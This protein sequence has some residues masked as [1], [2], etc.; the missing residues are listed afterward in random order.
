MD[1]TKAQSALKRFFGYDS[2]RPMQ[3]EII[4]TVLSGQDTLV[5][6]P[7]GGGK[8][9]C[10]Q[11]P[12]VLLPGI[13]VVVSPLIALMHDQ[14]EG[15]RANGIPAAYMNSTQ[16]FSEVQQLEIALQQGHIKLLYV[17]P[18]KLLSGHFLGFLRALG[19]SL[20]AIDE[21]HCI[22]AWG[23]DFRPEY[24]QLALLKEQ[25]PEVG[26]VALTAT[27]DR[28]TRQDIATQ[29]HMRDPRVFISSFDRPNLSLTVLPGQKKY[30]QIKTFLEQHPRQ[31]GIVYCLSRKATEQVAAKLL[32][33]GY[34][35]AYYH[36]GMSAQER[37]KV[38]NDFL[39]DRTPIICATIA[40]GMGIDKSNVRWVIHYNMPK[41]MEGYY[42]EIGRAGRDG[43]ASDTLLFY[44][45]S[46]VIALRG[47]V[48]DS[49]QK[50]LQM[51]KLDRMQ[52][53]AEAT[54]C[55][56]KILLS[57]FGEV[58]EQERC[59]N[60]DVCE[61]PPETFDGTIIAQKALSAIARL[62]QRQQAVSSTMLVD[63]LRGSSRIDLVQKGY[64]QI[65]TYGAGK[66]LTQAEW[67]S[68][69]L[70]LL[71]QGLLEIAYD[72]GHTLRLTEASRKVLF[73]KQPVRLTHHKTDYT[74]KALKAEQPVPGGH[75]QLENELF[76]TLREVRRKIADEQGVPPYI[77][78]SDKTLRQMAEAMPHSVDSMQKVSGVGEEKLRKYGSAFI[79]A[80]VRFAV[81]KAHQGKEL[82][83]VSPFLTYERYQQGR[84][85][86]DIGKQRGVHINAI[87]DHLGQLY[88]MGYQI[89]L[90]RFIEID[91][92]QAVKQA[93][94]R[95]GS[96]PTLSELQAQLPDMPLPNLRLAMA[97]VRREHF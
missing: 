88:E 1:L 56:R 34:K 41:N 71:H 5:L 7:T 15:L 38:Q 51:A 28:I 50:E 90:F 63:I 80:I 81:L 35:A 52:Q 75:V 66:D 53:Y 11:I 67:N 21:A 25:F 3:A 10:Y 39:R 64:N 78:F 16:S 18:E 85:P 62:Q 27:A 2:F 84:S 47:F 95:V 43:L 22:S 76:E 37:A 54:T 14:V 40:F 82:P 30:E 73:E 36:A 74:P 57:Y 68:Y 89:D 42:Q 33:D 29:L 49:G 31:S 6:M 19:V 20:F 8:S 61:N 55:R 91:D 4:E 93:L 77:V 59:G 79:S 92:L 65:A 72:Q 58:M 26:I 9:I 94:K 12:A 45:I 97:H 83:W 23:H 70:Q 96:K 32:K 46:D 24:T 60:C 87:Y 44:S 48:E 69:L 13:T 86:E 17:S